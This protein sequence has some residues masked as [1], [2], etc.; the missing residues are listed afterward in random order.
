MADKITYT[1]RGMGREKVGTFIVWEHLN[2][3]PVNEYTAYDRG[4]SFILYP[5]QRMMPSKVDLKKKTVL[6]RETRR[7]F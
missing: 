6:L 4:D 2:G 7:A 1:V 3:S 5:K